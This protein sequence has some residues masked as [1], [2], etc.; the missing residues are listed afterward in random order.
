ML[1]LLP[2]LFPVNKIWS[3]G[4][5]V[6]GSSCLFPGCCCRK[7]HTVEKTAIASSGRGREEWE[8]LQK[9]AQSIL[10]PKYGEL[11]AVPQSLCMTV[12]HTAGNVGEV[13]NLANWQVCGKSPN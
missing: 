12:Y 5:I 13:F 8:N 4:F 11:K 9:A 2:F 10:K 1:A 6:K 7:L 3:T